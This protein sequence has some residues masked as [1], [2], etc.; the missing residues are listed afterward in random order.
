MCESFLGVIYSYSLDFAYYHASRIYAYYYSPRI[1]LFI[2]LPE[3]FRVGL[4]ARQSV[5]TTELG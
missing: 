2:M 1:Y 5:R 4:S 3:K